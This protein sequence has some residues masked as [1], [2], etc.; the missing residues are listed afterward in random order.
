MKKKYTAKTDLSLNIRTGKGYAHIQFDSMTKGGSVYYTE[1]PSLQ[2]GL[3]KHPKY[4]RLFRMEVVKE[5]KREE[6]KLKPESEKKPKEVK[7][8]SLNDAKDYLVETHG[9]SRT[10]L[11]TKESILAAAAEVG[12]EFAGL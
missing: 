10:Q 4:G 1:N 3:E 7:V 11:R 6:P 5:V 12:E 2:E 9:Y 8:E